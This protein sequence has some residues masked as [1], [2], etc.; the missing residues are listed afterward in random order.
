MKHTSC[1]GCKYNTPVATAIN[2][3][4]YERL[5][6]ETMRSVRG[7]YER[8]LSCYIWDDTK[9]HRTNYSPA[10]EQAMKKIW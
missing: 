10:E 4:L 1:K 7:S 8:C 2:P 6:L 5:I 3:S 9:G